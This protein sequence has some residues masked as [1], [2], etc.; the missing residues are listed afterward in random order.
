[1]KTNAFLTSNQQFRPFR[2]CL[3]LI[4]SRAKIL[5]F[6]FRL[7]IWDGQNS[8]LIVTFGRQRATNGPFTPRYRVGDLR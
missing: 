8:I 5:A 4:R 1:M 2:F 3:K 7:D 6:V